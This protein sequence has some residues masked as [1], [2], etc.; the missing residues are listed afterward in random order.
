MYCGHKAKKKTI[1]DA[2]F[3]LSNGVRG[4]VVRPYLFAPWM[5]KCIQQ[6]ISM[7]QSPMGVLA[8]FSQNPMGV[9]AMFSQ[10]PVGVLA[11]K[12]INDKPTRWPAK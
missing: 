11:H 5:R 9:L 4:K 10:S 6:S 8:M 12:K 1:S 3:C 2:K 7:F